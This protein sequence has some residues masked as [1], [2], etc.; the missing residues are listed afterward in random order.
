VFLQEPVEGQAFLAE[1]RNEATQG[2]EAPNTF[3]TPLR[4]RI[5]PIRSRAATFSG[6]G[7]DASLG[8]NVS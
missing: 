2:G 5:G 7:L 3:W 1:P 8:D 6:V 4:S